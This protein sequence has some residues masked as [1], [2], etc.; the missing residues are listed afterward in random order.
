MTVSYGDYTR[1][2]LDKS[3]VWFQDANLRM[4]T[5]TPAVTREGQVAW[6]E[7]LPDRR[8]YKIWSLLLDSEPIGAFGLKNI[9]ESRAEYWGYI[10]DG[11]NRGKG[12]G[13]S[14]LVF[15]ERE[16]A[17]MGI[18]SLYLKVVFQNIRAI[19]IYFKRDFMISSTYDGGYVMEKTIV[20]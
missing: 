10:G 6:F 11:D 12:Y 18:D 5:S 4:L 16:A 8:D 15:S 13:E 1:Q 7:S 3:Y 17:D 9:S 2:A 19:N 14:M 20:S